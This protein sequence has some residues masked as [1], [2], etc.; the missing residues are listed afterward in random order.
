MR[1][2]CPICGA[3]YFTYGQKLDRAR[4]YAHA[5]KRADSKIGRRDAQLLQHARR[6][7]W[8]GEQFPVPQSTKKQVA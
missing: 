6:L 8:D 3:P 2:E 1:D 5:A 4:H 7:A